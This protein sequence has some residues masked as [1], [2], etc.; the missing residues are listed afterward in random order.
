MYSGFSLRAHA[1]NGS[2][3]KSA[4]VCRIWSW[5][6]YDTSVIILHNDELTF[7]TVK[8]MRVFLSFL[9]LRLSFR[10]VVSLAAVSAGH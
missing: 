5:K 8:F 3:G 6:R 7:H 4:N 9:L 2:A 1:S 10:G